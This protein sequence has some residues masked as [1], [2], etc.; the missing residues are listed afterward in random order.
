MTEREAVVA[1]LRE[2]KMRFEV[3]ADEERRDWG[4]SDKYSRLSGQ[5]SILRT[6][7]AYIERGDHLIGREVEAPSLGYQPAEERD[8]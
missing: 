6:M 4:P 8:E 5:A 3:A 2:E 1:F 7:A